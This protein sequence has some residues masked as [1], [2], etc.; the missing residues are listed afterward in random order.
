MIYTTA[1]K[2]AKS[3]GLELTRVEEW[4][5]VLQQVGKLE[6]AEMAQYLAKLVVSHQLGTLISGS[7][8]EKQEKLAHDA[9]IVKPLSLNGAANILHSIKG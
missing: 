8:S 4:I 2:F 9:R 6:D 5:G 7:P 3:Q 1:I